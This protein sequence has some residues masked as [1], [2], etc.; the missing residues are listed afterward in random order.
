MKIDIGFDMLDNISES[1]ALSLISE[2]HELGSE[3]KIEEKL[4]PKG[5]LTTGA[6]VVLITV[7]TATVAALAAIASFI[8]RVFHRGV[9]LD[10][11]RSSP[12]IRK[13]MD[14]PRGSV[15]ILYK[16]GRQELHQSVSGN[17]IGE[18]MNTA[19]NSITELPERPE[20]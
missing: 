9:I 12:R 2:L 14:L 5:L 15:L 20:D 4:E 16:N 18:L 10:L 19:I 17:K 7:S 3:A 1:D 11:T 6:V 8:Y 13:S